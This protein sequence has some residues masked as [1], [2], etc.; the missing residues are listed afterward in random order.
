[1]H[2]VR[3]A[4]LTQVPPRQTVALLVIISSSELQSGRDISAD[5]LTTVL[6]TRPAQSRKPAT[7]HDRP[8][9]ASQTLP[10]H[11]TN[12]PAA[13]ATGGS[14][15]HRSCGT[16]SARFSSP[17]AK[18]T[19]LPACVTSIRDDGKGRWAVTHRKESSY[20]VPEVT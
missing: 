4:V 3:F 2:D 18:D 8:I 20:R 14:L 10:M 11:Q 13:Q 9:D 7:A 19:C 6:I 5:C 15:T 16:Y 12:E 17:I 1:M